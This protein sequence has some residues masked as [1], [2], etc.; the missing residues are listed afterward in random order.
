[1][2]SMTRTVVAIS[3][4]CIVSCHPASAENL[5]LGIPLPLTGPEAKFGEIQK[6]SYEIAADEINAGGGIR[7]KRLILRFEDSRGKPDNARAIVERLIDVNG[8]IMIV[9]EYTSPCAMAVAAVAEERKIPYLVVASA[10]DDISR[11]NYK[12]V[13]RQNVSNAHYADGLIA[14]MKEV[15]KP[16]T[17]A[18][19]HESSAFGSSGANDM[20]KQADKLGYQ[21]LVKQE[22]RKGTIDFRLILSK[23]RAARPDVVYMVSYAADAALLMK[24]IQELRIDA[25]LF[26]GGAA[27]FAVPEF[28]NNAR[29]AAE[30]VV[31][32]TLWSPR[33]NL[34]GAW[35]YAKKYRMKYGDYPS[36]HGASAYAAMFVV[37]DALERA[38]SWKS[39]DIRGALKATNLMT[40]F[41]QIRF[42]DREGYQNQNFMDTL[43]LQVIQGRHE[44]IWPRSV[45]TKPYIYPIPPW[46]D[47][48]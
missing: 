37:K 21:V 40:A 42:E 47:R 29:S 1:M 38:K 18:I 48:H 20:E 43:V 28:I 5:V 34:P 11:K 13:F 30:Y 4:L 41:G 33:S 19:I 15:V 17:M 16:E 12:Y 45:A 35:A 24:Q 23:I 31:T 14:F 10:A 2:G 7:S 46:R 8:Q 25:G 22:Y 39:D 36:Y 44:T 3:V 6:H 32:A 9:G 26:A 27:G